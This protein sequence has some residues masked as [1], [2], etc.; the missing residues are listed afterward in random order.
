MMDGVSSFGCFVRKHDD[1]K[2]KI[3]DDMELLDF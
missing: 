2:K 1:G 3:D